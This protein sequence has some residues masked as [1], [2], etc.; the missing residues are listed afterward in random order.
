MS[1]DDRTAQAHL[2]PEARRELL[3]AFAD[4]MLCKITAMDDPE[5]ARAELALSKRA[6]TKSAPAPSFRRPPLNSG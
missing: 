6:Q 3:R 4:R 2:T 1:L 5:A